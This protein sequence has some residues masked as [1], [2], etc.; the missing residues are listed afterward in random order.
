LKDFKNRQQL[1]RFAGLNICRRQSG[2]YEGKVK[3]SKKGRVPLRYVLYQCVWSSTQKTKK[4]ALSVYYD[5]KRSEA[6][7]YDSAM[8][9]CMRKALKII[10]GAFHSES[11]YDSKHYEQYQTE[12]LSA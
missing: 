1:L 11:G 5:K 4:T 10:H 7:P 3:I 12:K 8:T 9:A 6:R 2:K